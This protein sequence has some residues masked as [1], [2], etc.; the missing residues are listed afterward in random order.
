[1]VRSCE[2]ILQFFIHHFLF[3]NPIS[4]LKIPASITYT[5]G[6]WHEMD[7]VNSS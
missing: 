4:W 6:P 2:P 7:A 3:A 5:Q 1:M